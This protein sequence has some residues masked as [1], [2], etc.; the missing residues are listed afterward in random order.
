MTA[1]KPYA[2]TGSIGSGKSTASKLLNQWGAEIID[3]DILAR[4]VVEAGSEGLQKVIEEFGPAF[5]QKDGSLNRDKLAKRVFKNSED[6]HKLESILHPRIRKKFLE[7]LEE[8]R[9]G[10]APV[11]YVVPLFFEAGLPRDD[12]E[13]VL[14]IAAEQNECL[15]RIMKRDSCT[16]KAAQ[17]KLESQ[18]PISQ[19]IKLADYVFWNHDGKQRDLEASLYDFFKKQMLAK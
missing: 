1:R 4:E 7:R 10:N 2:L 3:A 17:Q 11:V 9:H 12:F 8:L 14:L 13:A 15:K 16:E 18:I 19:K 5:L 6:R